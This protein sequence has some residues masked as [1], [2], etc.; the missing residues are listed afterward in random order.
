MEITKVLP[1][2]YN[3]AICPQ[4]NYMYVIK[5]K[6]TFQLLP[7]VV[8]IPNSLQ[9]INISSKVLMVFIRKPFML[10]HF[11]PHNIYVILCNVPQ[12][13]RHA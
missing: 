13:V 12:F 2:I 9:V 5:Y 11:A 4:V 8:C 6:V 3:A 7:Q 1:Y 10:L